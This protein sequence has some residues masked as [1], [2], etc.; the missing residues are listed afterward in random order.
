MKNK[1]TLIYI[2]G[3]GRSGSTILSTILGESEEIFNCAEL[4]HI[5][6]Y[7]YSKK[8][9]NDGKKL[10][11]SLFWSK[12]LKCYDPN[13]SKNYRA[14]YRSS[15]EMESHTSFLKTYAGKLEKNAL[16]DYTTEQNG[17]IKAISSTSNSFYI[18]DSSKYP[19]RALL[20]Q[21]NCDINLKII[22]NIRDVRGVIHSFSKNVQTQKSFFSAL[23][24]YIIINIICQLTYFRFKKSER[25]KIKYED[26][27]ENTRDTLLRISDFLSID[28]T[29]IINSIENGR[30]IE[31]GAVIEGNRMVKKRKIELYSDN[32]WRSKRGCF[33]RLFFYLS[34]LPLMLINK[35]K[36]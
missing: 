33:Y 30:K 35:Y 4:M 5:Y 21:K 20:L 24:Y 17:F 23:F 2:L 7:I 19:T 11:D 14:L 27:A 13:K 28:F 1:I 10:S 12:V 9:C 36:M 26:L 6:N 16:R 25:I 15:K 22:Y 31:I 32:E 34:A 3:A 29:E 8:K 18:V